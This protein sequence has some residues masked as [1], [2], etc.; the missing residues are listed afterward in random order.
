MKILIVLMLENVRKFSSHCPCV[1][2]GIGKEEKP[3]RV[4]KKKLS[5]LQNIFFFFLL[6]GPL[7]LSKLIMFSFLL[8]FK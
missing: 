3:M 4:E 7:L 5:Y 2:F 1:C 8:H 6:F